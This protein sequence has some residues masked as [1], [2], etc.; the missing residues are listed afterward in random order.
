MDAQGNVSVVLI[1]GSEPER[2]CI[3][4]KNG[5]AVTRMGFGYEDAIRDELRRRGLSD[6]DIDLLIEQGRSNPS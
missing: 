6:P 4:A 5:V 1:A 2:F 3:V